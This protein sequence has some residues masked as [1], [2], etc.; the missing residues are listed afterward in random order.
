MPNKHSRIETAVLDVMA[1]NFADAIDKTILL[2][3]LYSHKCAIHTK[4][5]IILCWAKETF[6]VQGIAWEYS[7]GT[8]YF[9][10]QQDLLLFTLKWLVQ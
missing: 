3:C 2:E 1:K 9:K 4:S 6:G 10:N 5:V 7:H 8:Y